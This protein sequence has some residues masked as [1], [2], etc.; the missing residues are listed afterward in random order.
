MSGRI[1]LTYSESTADYLF[2][3][4]FDEKEEGVF[5]RK[6]RK[7]NGRI[8]KQVVT[9]DKDGEVVSGEVPPYR[10]VVR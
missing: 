10:A 6:Y 9:L 1:N 4:G 2:V 7:H 5:T 3:L 8:D